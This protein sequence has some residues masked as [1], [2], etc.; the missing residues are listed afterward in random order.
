MKISGGF[1]VVAICDIHDVHDAE[2]IH[3]NDILNNFQME[4]F[5]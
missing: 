4:I 5:V 2:T 1:I 3:V